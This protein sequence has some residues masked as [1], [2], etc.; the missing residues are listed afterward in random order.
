VTISTKQ[1]EEIARLWM[2]PS[3]HDRNITALAHGLHHRVDKK[4]LCNE[5]YREL[6]KNRG[7]PGLIKLLTWAEAL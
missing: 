5:L 2:S 3:P 7:N 6:D 1:A 4:G